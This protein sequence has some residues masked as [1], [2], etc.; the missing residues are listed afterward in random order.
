M[1]SASTMFLRNSFHNDLFSDQDVTIMKRNSYP[2]HDIGYLVFKNCEP[3]FFKENF[4][5]FFPHFFV[6]FPHLS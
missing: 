3:L 2:I 6:A 4:N 1:L 5:H